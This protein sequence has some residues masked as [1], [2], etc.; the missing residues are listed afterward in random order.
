MSNLNGMSPNGYIPQSQRT[1]T[2]D[3]SD[4]TL[5]IATAIAVASVSAVLL[6]LWA[7]GHP[8]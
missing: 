7:W 4:Q 8:I 1:P 2:F 3:P 6:V 5:H